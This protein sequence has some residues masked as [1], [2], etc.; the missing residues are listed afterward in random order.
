MTNEPTFRSPDLLGR[1]DSRLLVIDVQEK[2]LKAIPDAA[3]LIGNIERL[4]RGATALEVP[5]SACEQYPQGLGPTIEP[6][7][8]LLEVA[9]GKLRFSSSE[10]FD[11]SRDASARSEETDG[12][13]PRSKVVVAGIE[14]HVCVQQS[15]FD[16]LSRG[17]AVYLAADAIGSR[18]EIDR[19]FALQRMRDAGVVVTTTEAILFEWCETAGCAGFKEISRLAKSR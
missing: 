12:D 19:Q 14:A 11:W 17:F 8:G 15:V 16:L 10:C 1:H 3:K 13:S 5:V 2:L 4:I 6:L 7:R 9:P 18:F